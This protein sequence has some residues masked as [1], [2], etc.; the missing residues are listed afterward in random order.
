VRR[1]NVTD[2]SQQLA[3]AVELIPNGIT[4]FVLTDVQKVVFEEALALACYW[5][6]SWRFASPTPTR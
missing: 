4:K 5:R 1:S 2:P 3:Y 6:T